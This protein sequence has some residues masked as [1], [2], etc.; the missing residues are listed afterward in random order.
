MSQ[1]NPSGIEKKGE[2]V[3]FVYYC[4]V[5]IVLNHLLLHSSEYTLYAVVMILV[6]SKLY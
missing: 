6:F 3:Y 1:I 5:S 4:T 2:H